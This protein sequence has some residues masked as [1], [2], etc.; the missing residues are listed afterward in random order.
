M[1]NH[2]DT[3][4]TLSG[5]SV[6]SSVVTP[7]TG[8]DSATLDWKGNRKWVHESR[9]R[10]NRPLAQSWNLTFCNS[11][12]IYIFKYYV[13]NYIYLIVLVT[14]NTIIFPGKPSF[15]FPK[16]YSIFCTLVELKRSSSSSSKRPPPPFEVV[17]LET[18]ASFCKIEQNW[19]KHYVYM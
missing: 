16:F 12:Y 4:S 15:V 6:D 8:T 14:K 17:V 18:G 13:N 10:E 19:I 5:T 3:V 9:T 1:Y 7:P 2:G 11:L